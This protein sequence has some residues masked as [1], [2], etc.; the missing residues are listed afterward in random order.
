MPVFLLIAAF[1]LQT[2][3]SD[4]AVLTKGK[5]PKIKISTYSWRSCDIIL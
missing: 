4:R 5:H 2:A 1:S 3:G